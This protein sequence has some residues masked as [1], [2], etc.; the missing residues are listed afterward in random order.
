MTW[1]KPWLDRHLT[2]PY[3]GLRLATRGQTLDCPGEHTFPIVAGVPVLL[4]EDRPPTHHL[5]WTTAKDVVSHREL[6]TSDNAAAPSVDPFVERWLMATCGQLYRHYRRPLLRYPI[7]E[8]RLRPTSGDVLLDVGSNWGRWALAASRAGFKAVAVDPSLTAALAGRR[9][10]RQLG[11]EVAYV[12]A[13]ARHLPFGADSIDVTFSYSVLQHL[14]KA[15]VTEIVREM[16][17]VTRSGGRVR[18]Q[19]ANVLGHRQLYNQA[20]AFL[21]RARDSLNLVHRQPYGFRVRIWTPGEIRRLFSTLVGPTSL[22]PDG[23]FSLNAQ[24]SDLDLLDP[25]SATVVRASQALCRLARWTP[26]L[27]GLADS[28]LVEAV[29]E[30]PRPAP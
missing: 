5:W 14:D 12:V 16:S 15:D 28:L 25:L 10:A 18:V 29:N 19:M 3:D 2:C 30:K 9:I 26:G 22:S 24:P 23:F 1:I 20:T 7:P 17:R 6:V 11:F 21:S 4:R 8:I 27:V 13:D